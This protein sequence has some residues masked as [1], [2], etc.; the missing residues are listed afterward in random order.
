MTTDA[1]HATLSGDFT[2]VL[3]LG[4]GITM[5]EVTGSG[6]ATLTESFAQHAAL[7]DRMRSTPASHALAV[8][9]YSFPSAKRVIAQFSG[10]RD[11]ILYDYDDA[12]DHDESIYTVAPT[13]GFTGDKRIQQRLYLNMLS[14]QPVGRDHWTAARPPFALIDVDLKLTADGDNAKAEVI[15]T[16]LRPI[17]GENVLRFA[18]ADEEIVKENTAARAFHVRAVTDE[19]GHPLPF[20]HQLGDLVVAVDGLT[21][22]AIKLKFTIDGDFL[23]REG[24]DNAWQLGL[25]EPW[26]PLPR[27]LGGM[28]YTVHSLVKV[29]KPFVPFTP[30]KTIAR[31]EEGDYNLVETVLD[32]PVPFT[33]VQAGKYQLSEEKRGERT[34]RVATYGLRN[35]RA[36]KQLT[37]LAFGLIE[38]Y[39][40]FLG[41]FPW[42][43]FNIIQ[44]NT[45]GYGQ[46]PPATMFITSEAFQPTQSIETSC[47]RRGLTNVS[48]MRS[49]TSTGATSCASRRERKRGFPSHSPNTLPRWR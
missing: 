15:E 37:A 38:Y 28:A 8:Q 20:D 5:P 12:E 4:G 36:A 1:T 11:N 26:F 49:H 19:Q 18:M 9:K 35:D 29:K 30:G 21:A 44:M 34:I 22:A 32:K 2:D 6:G 40:V 45:Y 43:E 48:R 27:Q 14:A 24:G 39:E 10:G 16:I 13:T 47:F 46:A 42:S 33:M 31:R 25:G 3:I 41:P 23:V 7:Y 17:A